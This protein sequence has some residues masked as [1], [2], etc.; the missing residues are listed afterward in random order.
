MHPF[1]AARGRLG[2]VALGAALLVSASLGGAPAQAQSS[3]VTLVLE[4]WRSEDTSIWEDKIIPAYKA[5]HPNV[6]ITFRPTPNQ[7]YA[8][9]L[10]TELQGGTA[11]DVFACPP[12][13][14]SAGFYNQGYLPNVSDM[15]EL[16]HFSALARSGWSTPDGSVTYCMPV[17]SV[18]EG[19]TYNKDAF[20]KLGLKPPTTQAE[21]LQVLQA[22]KNDGTYIPLAMGTADSWT[23]GV[24]GYYSVGPNF[25][26]G[27]DGRQALIHGTAKLTDQPY[28]DTWRY[29]QQWGPFLPPGAEAVKYT[30][31]QQMF[32]LGKAAIMPAGSWE[33]SLFRESAKFEMGVFPPPVAN[34]GD[35]PY[36]DQMI[37]IGFTYNPKSANI[38]AAKQFVEWTGT[39]DFATLYSNALPGFFTLGDYQVQLQDPLAQQYMTWLANSKTTIRLPVQYLSAG[40]P[41][42]DSDLATLTGQVLTGAISPEDAGSQAQQDLDSWYKP[43]QQ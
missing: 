41:S 8:A 4:S 33:I 32:P 30:D 21:F 18:M 37:D 43:P 17:S 6:D 19:F 35:Q 20:S 29:L 1:L 11:G 14:T 38:D 34:A 39:A 26:H 2:A 27:E 15:S 28:I 25:W 13:D 42:L 5:T 22:I 16:S 9:A 12:F 7:Y 36:I 23:D 3:P 31:T 40:T 10:G 24:M